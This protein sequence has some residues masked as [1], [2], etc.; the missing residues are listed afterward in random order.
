MVR[1]EPCPHCKGN[2]II[3]IKTPTGKQSW[4]KCPVCAGVG[5]R[6]RL[7]H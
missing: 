7:L 4:A 3:E 5:Y 2:R 1:R 6:V